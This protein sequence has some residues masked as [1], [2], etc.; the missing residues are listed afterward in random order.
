MS[1]ALGLLTSNLYV[2]LKSQ[3]IITKINERNKSPGFGTTLS[4]RASDALRRNFGALQPKC[5]HGS[6][7]KIAGS[8]SHAILQNMSALIAFEKFSF[9]DWYRV[10]LRRALFPCETEEQIRRWEGEVSQL[11]CLDDSAVGDLTR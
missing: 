11:F 10:V 3:N 2:L 4:A 9:S 7:E 8:R 5:S 1:D 6:P